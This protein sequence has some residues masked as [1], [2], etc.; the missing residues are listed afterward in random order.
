MLNYIFGNFCVLQFMPAKISTAQI[1]KNKVIWAA[2][3]EQG[4]NWISQL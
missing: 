3:W 4:S 1:V 2:Q